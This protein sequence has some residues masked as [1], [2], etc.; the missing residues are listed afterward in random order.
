MGGTE[1]LTPDTGIALLATVLGAVWAFFKS[2]A[3]YGQARQRRY[4]S[5]VQA[6][7]AGVEQTNRAYGKALTAAREDGRLTEGEKRTARERAKQSAIE[8]G[9]AQGVDVMKELGSAYLDLWVTRLVKK[10]KGA[11]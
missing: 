5:A 11:S 8:F 6:V 4:F 10:L 2:S 9:F 3:W 7:E 1:I